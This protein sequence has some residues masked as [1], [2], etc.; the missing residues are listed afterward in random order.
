MT[1][2]SQTSSINYTGNGTTTIFAYNF[3]TLDQTWLQ[4]YVDGVLKTLTTHY[5]VS[6]VGSASGGNITF[7][8]APSNGSAVYIARSNVPATQLVDYTANDSFPAETHETALDKLT[9]LVQS[10]VSSVSKAI[11]LTNSETSTTA[12]TI[13]TSVTA[14]AK[15]L[16]F[17]NSAGE[18][19][20]TENQPNTVLAFNES[21][22]VSYETLPQGSPIG[23]FL[24]SGSGAV[25]RTY[26]N[27]ARE[28]IS[29]KDFGAVGDGVADDTSAIQAAINS[30]TSG[31][32]EFPHASY[33]CRQ[34]T[35]QSN[36]SMRG[37]N[38]TITS[39]LLGT[40]IAQ[41]IFLGSDK[42]NISIDG[43]NFVDSGTWTSTP[44]AYPT[45]GGNSVGWTN[46]HYA[47]WLSG[48]SNTIQN[49]EIVNCSATG[50]L[51]C[52][53]VSK[54]NNVAIHNNSCLSNGESGI[55]LDVTSNATV[56]NNLITTLS[57][58]MTAAGD[59][60]VSSSKFADGVYLAAVTY[61]NVSHN[62]I[63][64][65]IRI[66]IVLEGD[67]TGTPDLNH[68]I[69]VDNNVIFNM[70]N[71]RGTENNAA[72]WAEPPYS[73]NCTISNN[74]CDN[75]MVSEASGDKIGIFGYGCTVDNNYIEKFEFGVKAINASITNNYILDS[76]AYGI[77]SISQAS[78]NLFINSNTIINS[79]SDGIR[80]Q[81]CTCHAYIN[82]NTLTANGGVGIYLPTHIGNAT[83]TGNTISL[84]NKSGIQL[85]SYTA[86]TCIIKNNEIIDNGQSVTEIYS[87]SGILQN[88]I[89]ISGKVLIE[90][91][92]FICNANSGDTTGQ[93]Y[94]IVQ[95][96]G[97][98]IAYTS[99]AV[100]R[101]SF[102]FNGTHS[103][104][105]VAP[106]TFAKSNGSPVVITPEEIKLKQNNYNDKYTILVDGA[107]E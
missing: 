6:G 2:Q 26:Q 102:V 65:V 23:T 56:F 22:E 12:K 85:N 107:L 43:F 51:A 44:F 19:S 38:S 97:G 79:T 54:A 25:E 21:G 66:G 94:S 89:K 81:G 49:I 67:G 99:A 104:A 39:A 78:G 48:I 42:S 18:L 47:I 20:Y 52:F 46:R 95:I 62:I 86:G 83:I 14:R 73:Y 35:L 77:F 84:S 68:N 28:V 8:T 60:N 87:R 72:I 53:R 55:R 63:S 101:N 105:G 98:D 27:K 31:I 3:K 71:A 57:G 58:N 50:F 4:I 82:D 10:L 74:H 96:S 61:S 106:C 37:N 16:L 7:V 59:T 13:I 17:F 33:K 29:V 92:T 100:W 41:P 93:L 90:Q 1:I 15:R 88:S 5:T 9:L 45:G 30:L 34:V 75:S 24:Q 70:N 91:N 80:V 64:D 36:V 103:A 32:V 11:Q 76:I 69:I 40:Q